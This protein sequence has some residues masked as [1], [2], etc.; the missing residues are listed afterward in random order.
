MVLQ[1]RQKSIAGVAQ[2][3]KQGAFLGGIA[4]IGYDIVDAKYVINDREAEAIRL[5]FEQYA[6]GESYNAIIDMLA[7][8]GYNGKRGQ[9][10]GKSSINA[11]LR[12]ARYKGV[13][14]WNEHQYKNMGKWAGGQLNPAVVKI[15][16]GI[17]AIINEDTWGG[18]R[19]G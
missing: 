19:T 1:T 18:Y 4:P 12:N 14:I 8:T 5:I 6:A 13:Y 11:I 9:I 7:D 16:G 2:K 3:A 15:D 10:M 17:P